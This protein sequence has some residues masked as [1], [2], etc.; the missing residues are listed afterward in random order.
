MSKTATME[1]KKLELSEYTIES[2]DGRIYCSMLIPNGT[3]FSDG[4]EL[5]SSMKVAKGHRIREV[6]IFGKKFIE[7][8]LKEP[9]RYV[10]QKATDAKLDTVPRKIDC[11]SCER[12]QAFQ[13]RLNEE[14]ENKRQG[15]GAEI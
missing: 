1:L 3:C 5:A 2:P 13:I 10:C 6:L 15:A 14:V 8:L 12:Y 9:N 7:D 4:Y 11:S